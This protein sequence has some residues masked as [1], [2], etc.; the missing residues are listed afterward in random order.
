MRKYRHEPVLAASWRLPSTATRKC[1]AFCP[2]GGSAPGR[3]STRSFLT[4]RG[5]PLQISLANC[6]PEAQWRNQVVTSHDDPNG[7]R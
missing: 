5:G 7:S 6:S 4:E 3:H 2:S 1:L